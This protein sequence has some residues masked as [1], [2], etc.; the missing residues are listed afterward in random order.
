MTGQVQSAAGARP[1]TPGEKQELRE[2][3]G[4]QPDMVA[5]ASAATASQQASAAAADAAAFAG[6]KA[7]DAAVSASAAAASTVAATAK[8]IEVQASATAA[9]ASAATASA[10]AATATAK[11]S[12]ASVSATSAVGGAMAAGMKAADAQAAAMAAAGSAVSAATSA[13]TATTKASEVQTAATAAVSGAATATT[14]AGDAQTSATAAAGSAATATT[15]AS[16]AQTSATAAASSATTATTR[17]A[18][19]AASATAAVGS[20]VLHVNAADPH[21]GK[22]ASTAQGAKAESA[23]Q[24][25]PQLTAA[26]VA[27]AT[28]VG[29]AVLGAADAAA[30]REALGLGPVA[31]MSLA[32]A[33]SSVSGAFA[34]SFTAT[35]SLSGNKVMP[36]QTVGGALAFTL[37]AS[38]I[39]FGQCYV[40]L[41]AD[42]ANAPTF[43]GF[44]EHGSSAGYNNTSGII[45][46]V[47]FWHDG[48]T[49]WYS[50]QQAANAV[51]VVVPSLSSATITAASPTQI[52]LV[53]ADTLNSASTPN[54][55]AFVIANTGGSD[56]VTGVAIS[57][58][59]VTLTKSRTTLSTDVVT[60]SY[61]VPGTSAL[62]S[63]S[64]VSVGAIT[65]AAVNNQ[66]AIQV[67]RLSSLVGYTES[68]NAS[69]YS[70]TSTTNS[71]SSVAGIANLGIAGDGYVTFP[72]SATAVGLLI[73]GLDN[74]NDGAN[75]TSVDF[76]IQSNGIGS[77]YVLIL[78]GSANNAANGTATTCATGDLLRIQRTGTVGYARISKDGGATWILL[79]TMASGLTSAKLWPKINGGAPSPIVIGPVTAFGAT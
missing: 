21:P 3:F 37:A 11:A 53:F 45:N 6:I 58:N 26:A 52:Q 27:A 66:L 18:E 49:A 12:E 4:I 14:M 16:D 44:T 36:Q 63:N 31:T 42:G 55:S 48:T 64:G 19:A 70:Y 51:P 68:G 43:P 76:G 67:I 78:N 57:G 33:Q 35:V 40:R 77:P 79:H 60:I 32:Q 23:L 10:G 62:V 22:Y 8:A 20:M 29:V 17:A 2:L 61:T 46:G 15:K 73:L 38:P 9:A 7:G 39:L 5:A 56:T 1:L 13:A 41:V 47:T 54:P 74:A 25:G 65:A 69:G 59:T 71:A 30:Q 72:L 50:V 28:A 24:P 34:V 75:Y